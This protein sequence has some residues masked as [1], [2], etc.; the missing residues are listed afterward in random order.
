MG[1]YKRVAVA[2]NE[3]YYHYIIPLRGKILVES[4]KDY[5]YFAEYDLE[6]KT[7]EAGV[8]KSRRLLVKEEIFNKKLCETY[9]KQYKTYFDER[10]CK[11][12]DGKI[13][14]GKL[15]YESRK[16]IKLK[17]ISRI[18][19]EAKCNYYQKNKDEMVT[20]E[21]ARAGAAD[22]TGADI[23]EKEVCAAWQEE[24]LLSQPVI[25]KDRGKGRRPLH[26]KSLM[27]E[28]AAVANLREE[29]DAEKIKKVKEKVLP[30]LRDKDGPS[31]SELKEEINQEIAAKREDI[32]ELLD[33]SRTKTGKMLVI[34]TK[35]EIE[36]LELCLEYA[37][38][39]LIYKNNWQEG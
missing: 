18:V 35:Q 17:E 39:F 29:N 10:N 25:F 24:G 2:Q 32:F 5:D 31:Y 34:V 14:S 23:P 11:V 36:V 21:E 16:R 7:N 27:Y 9:Y 22:I 28:I 13:L 37:R 8:I 1:L 38:L 4:N 3:P 20:I 15:S 12:A 26:C 30:G 6:T 19:Y 33:K